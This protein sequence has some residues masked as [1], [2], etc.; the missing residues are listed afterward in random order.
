MPIFEYQCQNCGHK[1]EELV[2]G[3]EEIKCPKCQSASLKKLFSAPNV[4][5][6]SKSS[7]SKDSQG[8]SCCSSCGICGS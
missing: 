7:D 6:K 4:S 5:K 3:K 2:L 8:G 1:F